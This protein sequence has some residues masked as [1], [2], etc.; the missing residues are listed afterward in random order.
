MNQQ[1][2]LVQSRIEELRRLLNRY[3]YEYY[4]LDASTIED[5]QFDILMKELE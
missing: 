1:S 5:R 3:N 2:N 4:V